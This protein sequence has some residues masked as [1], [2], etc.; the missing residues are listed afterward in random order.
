MHLGEEMCDPALFEGSANVVRKV[1][2]IFAQNPNAI[3][4][5]PIRVLRAGFESLDEGL[6]LS[7]AGKASGEKIVVRMNKL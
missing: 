7:R 6:D 1:N 4:N 3:R 2:D 5:M